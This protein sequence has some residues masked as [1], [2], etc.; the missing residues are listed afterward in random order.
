MDR[1]CS[2]TYLITVLNPGFYLTAEKFSSLLE[3]NI[4]FLQIRKTHPASLLGLLN[5]VVTH[6]LKTKDR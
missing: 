6:I 4:K 1:V 5:P 3:L 2:A